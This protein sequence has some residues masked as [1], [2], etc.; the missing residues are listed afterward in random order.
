MYHR[1]DKESFV[2][3]SFPLYFMSLINFSPIPSTGRLKIYEKDDG[4]MN[5]RNGGVSRIRKK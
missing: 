5:Q 1:K 2:S 4:L 3:E